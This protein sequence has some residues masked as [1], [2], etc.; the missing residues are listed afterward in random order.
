MA[1][2]DLARRV[3]QQRSDIDALYELT[4]EMREEMRDGL[5][6]VNMKLDR[7]VGALDG[8]VDAVDGRVGRVEGKVDTL[9]RKVDDG[10]AAITAQLAELLRGGAGG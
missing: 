4:S 5:R 3:Q 6:A 1:D 9:D 8:K 7:M 2:P 10:F